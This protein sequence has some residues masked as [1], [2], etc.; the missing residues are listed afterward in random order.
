MLIH[1]PGQFFDLHKDSDKEKNM[2]AS[3][4]IVLPCSH[5]GG[6]LII[7]HQNKQH[8]FFG[9]RN[10]DFI[11]CVMFSSDCQHKIKKVTEGFRIALTYNVF[12]CLQK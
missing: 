10:P 7:K 9:S 8:V 6:D 3:L 12:C 11:K 2:V 1:S 4:V 5:K